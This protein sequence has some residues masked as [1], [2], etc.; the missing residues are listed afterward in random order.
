MCVKLYMDVSYFVLFIAAVFRSKKHLMG[1]A[2]SA[3]DPRL[4]VVPG[5]P[6]TPE[7]GTL[8]PIVV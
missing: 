7:F 3:A 8:V 1:L 2:A 6:R 4:P 5:L